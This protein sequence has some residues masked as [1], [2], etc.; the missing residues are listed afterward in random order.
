[1]RKGVNR[2]KK[3]VE[4]QIEKV[5]PSSMQFFTLRVRSVLNSFNNFYNQA[6]NA[7]ELGPTQ[8]IDLP[9]HAEYGPETNFW[10]KFRPYLTCTHSPRL[11]PEFG[12]LKHWCNFEW[13]HEN[14]P[15]YVLSLGSGND[16]SYEDVLMSMFPESKVVTADCYSQPEN[17]YNDPDNPRDPKRLIYVSECL[18]GPR[19]DARIAFPPEA[20]VS[21]YPDFA[22]R[23]QTNHNIPYFDLH[24]MN[25]EASEYS[26]YGFIMRNPDENMRNTKMIQMELHRLG[27]A[28]HG[29]NWDSMLV[30]ELFFATMYSG[31]Y[32]AVAYEKWDDINAAA[33]FVFVNQSWFL[34]SEM[35]AYEKV[36]DEPFPHSRGDAE[37]VSR[38]FNWNDFFYGKGLHGGANDGSV[39]CFFDNRAGDEVVMHWVHPETGEQ[40]HAST[41]VVNGVGKINTF[42]GHTFVWSSKGKHGG[43]V[44][45]EFGTTNYRLEFSTEKKEEL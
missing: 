18:Q 35:N 29:L 26:T 4:E 27:M 24:K 38:S 20:M 40:Q 41:I 14:K 11:G 13:F 1:M 3:Q 45:V 6:V 2:F 43:S 32:H 16:F 8:L 21:T 25:I 44:T 17:A 9:Q 31:G 23:L 15:K 37:S 28:D 42:V 36:I 5:K 7:I 39:E 12:G 33:D 19:N 10:L 22:N 34:E 30:Y